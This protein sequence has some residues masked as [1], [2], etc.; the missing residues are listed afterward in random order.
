MTYGELL[1]KR[2]KLDSVNFIPDANNKFVYAVA[3][4][5]DKMDS[6]K[7]SL[8]K[9]IKPDDAYVKYQEELDVINRK[10]AIKD[11]DGTISFVTIQTKQGVQRGYKKLVGEGN[12]E[13]DFEKDIKKLKEKYKKEIEEQEAKEKIYDK[14]LEEEIPED[15][16]RIFFIDADIIPDGLHP[17]G[18]E[19]CLHF[20]REP[21]EEKPA[22]VKKTNKK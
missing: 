6:I 11:P 16:Y 21:E 13:S 8:E 1:E 18:M 19:G 15:D 20:T 4:N 9:M 12:P 14:R 3:R 5:K 10:Y 22:Q 2:R 17:V 7:K